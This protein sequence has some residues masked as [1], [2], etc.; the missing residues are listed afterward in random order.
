MLTR[1]I[2]AA[3]VGVVACL[4]LG[5]SGGTPD[6]HAPDPGGDPQAG[7]HHRGGK[8]PQAAI[9][10]CKGKN[11]GDECT[12]SHDGHDKKGICGNPPDDI[13]TLACRHD[14][15]PPGGA[16]VPGGAPPPPTP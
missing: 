13:A 5:C 10:A 3:V 7:G 15:P 16:Q 1:S 8:P 11:S 6:P 4:A 12:V 14:G 2:L 9:D